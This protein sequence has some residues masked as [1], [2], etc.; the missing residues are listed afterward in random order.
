MH[1]NDSACVFAI[2]RTKVFINCINLQ[3]CQGDGAQGGVSWGLNSS[4][5]SRL[6][7]KGK[8]LL[9]FLLAFSSQR[10][11]G[12]KGMEHMQEGN[13]VAPSLKRHII[14]YDLICLFS[15]LV[16]CLLRFVVLQ[17]KSKMLL[18]VYWIT[19][20]VAA[21]PIQCEIMLTTWLNSSAVPLLWPTRPRNSHISTF[22]HI[23]ICMYVC[24]YV[25][26]LDYAASVQNRALYTSHWQYQ[27][28]RA[29]T[30]WARV[31]EV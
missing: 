2:E 31:H 17:M 13:P 3:S 22:I 7:G 11:T 21:H 27:R 16:L 14:F 18:I 15:F 24:G 28:K 4:S 30:S 6:H 29:L 10:A 19:G 5:Y 20:N 1:K 8:S 23:Y 25:M 12:E 9:I 26:Q